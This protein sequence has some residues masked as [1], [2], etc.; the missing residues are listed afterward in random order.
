MERSGGKPLIAAFLR[1]QTR[2]RRSARPLLRE[3]PMHMKSAALLL[4]AACVVGFAPTRGRAHGHSDGHFVVFASL[5]ADVKRGAAAHTDHTEDAWAVADTVFSLSHDRLRLFGEFNASSRE[6]DMERLQLGFEPIPDTV[7]WLGRFHQPASAWNIE[8]H[9]GRFLQ[10]SITRPSIEFWEDE[11]GPLPQHLVGALIESR[12]PLGRAA[13]LQLEVGIGAGSVLEKD[14]LESVEILERSPGSR[15]ISTTARV[16]Y[17]PQYLG[18]SSVGLLYG[19]HDVPVHDAALAARIGASR[20]GQDI[21]GAFVDLGREVWRLKAVVY[22]I[23]LTFRGG[24]IADRHNVAAGYLQVERQLPRA[25]TLYFRHE[26]SANASASSYFRIFDDDFTL[27]GNL[28]G[29]RW[30]FRRQQALTVEVIRKNT[31]AGVSSEGRLQWSAA[32][33]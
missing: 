32:F 18:M 5:Q 15:R 28:T 26:N 9:H 7:I 22:D 8:H 30:D 21:Y 23:D 13:G 19:H 25:L 16:A 17:L 27:R 10:T 11:E 1:R 4:A 24:A 33:P 20:V 12:R 3:I 29:L 31:I 2:I 14:K 6:L